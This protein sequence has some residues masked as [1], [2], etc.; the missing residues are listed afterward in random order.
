MHKYAYEAL[1]F[2][3]HNPAVVRHSRTTLEIGSKKKYKISGNRTVWAAI[4]PAMFDA[5]VRP[6][7]KKFDP[8]CEGWEPDKYWHF[9]YAMHACYGRYINAITIPELTAAVLRLDNLRRAK[10][11][12]GLSLDDGPFPNNFVVEFDP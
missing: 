9:G 8:D 4:T 6:D 12:V 1:R 2:N 5:A 11:R 3:P 7:P 10:S